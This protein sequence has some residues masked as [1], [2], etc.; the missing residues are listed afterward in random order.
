ML[1]TGR[2]HDG[3]GKGTAGKEIG[4]LM[5]LFWTAIVA[6]LILT[7]P[8]AAQRVDSAYTKIDFDACILLDADDLGASFAC[9]GYKGFPLYV[10]E[11]DLRMFVSYGFGAPDEMAAHQTLP[12]FN[13][14]NET[15]EWRLVETEYGLRPF[16]SIL[17]FFTEIGDGSEPD[18]Q[19]LVVTK[20]APGNTCHIAYI[21]ALTVPDA[22]TVARQFADG[23]AP[24]FDCRSDTPRRLPE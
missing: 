19:T 15:L 4:M 13:T 12:R 14:I 5:R 2:R 1:V 3:K 10:A 21:D 18:G 7:G 23:L 11:G 6:L 16:A 22:N 8:A 9:P 24:V 20:I 17:R